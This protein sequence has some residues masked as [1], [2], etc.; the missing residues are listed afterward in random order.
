M[1][2]LLP[3]K[4]LKTYE[5][6]WRYRLQCFKFRLDSSALAVVF[7]LIDPL[8]DLTCSEYLINRKIVF[9]MLMSSLCH[10]FLY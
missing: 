6:F 9:R 4:A 1:A 8:F 3:S 2:K 5:T 7:Q 10:I